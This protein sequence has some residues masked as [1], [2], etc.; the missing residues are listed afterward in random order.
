MK[1][2]DAVADYLT[3]CGVHGY[4]NGTLRARRYYLAS[5]LSFIDQR[6]LFEAE[7]HSERA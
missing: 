2:S 3:W 6:E 5:F 7:N 1:T 4:S